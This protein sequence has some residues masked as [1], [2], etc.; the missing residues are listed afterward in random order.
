MPE[1][2]PFVEVRVGLL[3]TGSAMLQPTLSPPAILGA[4]VRTSMTPGRR[5]S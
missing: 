3:L 5:R 1:L 2:D 4:A